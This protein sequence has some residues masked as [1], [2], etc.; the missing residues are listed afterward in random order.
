MAVTPHLSYQEEVSD[1][2]LQL[3][4]LSIEYLDQSEI[5]VYLN[6]TL[7]TAWTWVGPAEIHLNSPAAD[8]VVVRVQRTTDS[9]ELRH[10]FS[11]GAAFR[12]QILDEDFYQILHIAQETQETL[13]GSGANDL[14]FSVNQ[15]Y[16][17][18]S[19]GEALVSRGVCAVD[20]PFSADPTGVADASIA[21]QAAVD[22]AAT[23]GTAIIPAKAFIVKARVDLPQGQ[24]R[25]DSTVI[26]PDG[27]VLAGA[28][29][30]NT[31]IVPTSP[32]IAIQMG[33]PDREHANVYVTDLCIRGNR[34]GPLTYGAWTTSTEVGIY[35][36][37]CIRQCGVRDCWVSECDILLKTENSYA[38]EVSSNLFTYAKSNWVHTDNMV[39]WFVANNRCDWAE[40]SG[41]YGNGTDAGDETVAPIFIG[42][43]FQIAWKNAVHLY[44]CTSATF[45]GNFFEANYREAT[46]NSSHVYADINI[47]TGPNNRGLAFTVQGN[48][49]THGSSPNFDAY[50]AIRCDRAEALTVIGN[51]CRD[52]LYWR[53]IDA[54]T[55]NV[56]RVINL[57]N[58][59][60]GAFTIAAYD[61]ANSGG[62][63]E[64]QDGAGVI[65]IPRLRAG[66]IGV[67][68]TIT[69]SNVSTTASRSLYKINCSAGNRIL[70]L[71]DAECAARA[72]IFAK[73]DD[74][75]ATFSLTVQ[76][77]AT[78]TIDGA[79][80][81]VLNTAWG[82]AILVG[83][84]TNWSV[85][86]GA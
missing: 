82:A 31:F 75:A 61:S 50:T 44:D 56:K 52:S 9:S 69:G 18:G 51:Q 21:V 60:T 63:I 48:F 27:V 41:W 80:S 20:A 22:Y 58:A 38:F 79:T 77:E 11:A 5:T 74:G 35:A 3:I 49:F 64:E 34:T 46:S 19:V 10:A 47:E 14:A 78:A 43:R 6:G 29:K 85:F 86:K 55:A 17:R 26:V 2:T 83:D 25:W 65:T 73:K 1:G 15:A 42:N 7:T 68:P 66:L 57:G 16:A 70:T 37:N 62:I 39:S 36:V 40:G 12:P 67:N 81:L 84:G 24:Y 54:A 32:I 4:A 28:G 13:R 30:S 53:F 72:V 23:Q 45:I 71:R 76:R 33:T 8:G 59:T